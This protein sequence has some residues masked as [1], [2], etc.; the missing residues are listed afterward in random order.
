MPDVILQWASRMKKLSKYFVL[1]CSIFSNSV[2]A[3]DWGALKIYAH[4]DWSMWEP[5]AKKAP[6]YPRK[7]FNKEIEGCVN[8]YFDIDSEG[9]LGVA[10]VIKSIPDGVFDKYA[11]KAL[12]AFQYRASEA[13]LSKE[14]ILTNNIFTFTVKGSEESRSKWTAECS[15]I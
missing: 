4:D 1:F 2:Y 11:L 7:L 8:I 10:K 15:K 6:Q 14:P 5:I 3:S 12:S 9:N 13:N